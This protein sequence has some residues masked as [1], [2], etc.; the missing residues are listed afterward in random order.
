M[1]IIINSIYQPYTLKVAKEIVNHQ[2]ANNV[3]GVFLDEEFIKNK[4]F[5]TVEN[6]THKQCLWADYENKKFNNDTIPLDD[7]ILK[8]FSPYMLSAL[9][10][11]DRVGDGK[12]SFEDRLA[13]VYKN[14]EY[15]NTMIERYNIEKYVSFDIPHEVY[16]YIIYAL[17][18]IKNI[19]C[20][21]SYISFVEG[22]SYIVRDIQTTGIEIKDLYDELLEVYKDV[23]I[24]DIPLNGDFLNT[25]NKRT[26][27]ENVIPFYMANVPDEKKVFTP[28]GRVKNIVN[29]IKKEGINKSVSNHLSYLRAK[30]TQ[31]YKSNEEYMTYFESKCKNCKVD[32]PYIYFPLHMQPECT[33]SPMGGN[34]VWQELA[35]RMLSKA[36]GENGYIIVK[37]NPKQ[38]YKSR[39]KE[40]VDGLADIKNV[41]LVPRS[42]DTFKLIDNSLAVATITGTVSI[43]AAFKG[44]PT[45]MFGDII[46]N[47]LPGVYNVRNNE[48]VQDTLN[49][50]LNENINITK[51]ELKIFM[52]AL[53]KCCYLGFSNY[54]PL[55]KNV[56]KEEVVKSMSD[57]INKAITQGG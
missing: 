11:V 9:K 54:N 21:F 48:Q 38:S 35:I 30:K 31:L 24:D 55:E 43:E 57:A 15:W 51:K 4:K 41:I 53:S 52:L 36:M 42:Q 56:S 27:K 47:Y 34:F 13:I 1:N 16:D 23:D 37:E 28:I 26:R 7:K 10:M 33:T 18:K 5:D 20:V 6:F 45:I 12:M 49:T 3:I 44:K 22:Y 50:L 29:T 46:N 25:Y 17:C 14:L 32:K 8:D 2:N 39:S 19:D 40:F